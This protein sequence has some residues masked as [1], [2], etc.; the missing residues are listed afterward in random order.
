MPWLTLAGVAAVS[1]PPH[2]PTES[3]NARHIPPSTTEVPL[4]A[5]IARPPLDG[6]GSGDA[7]RDPTATRGGARAETRVCA[8]P[9]EMGHGSRRSACDLFV[10]AEAR[11]EQRP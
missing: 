3:D 8:V 9:A 10:A 5:C 2:A 6:C 11:P 4:R 7:T 1:M